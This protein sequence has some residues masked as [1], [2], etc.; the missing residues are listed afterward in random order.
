[1][2]ATAS[3][4]PNVEFVKE[5]TLKKTVQPQGCTA[6]SAKSYILRVQINVPLRAVKR[7]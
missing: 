5:I 1:M 4:L 7:V 6:V 2:I 3:P